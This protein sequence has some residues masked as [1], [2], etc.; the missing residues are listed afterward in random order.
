ME[1]HSVA[2]CRE[3]SDGFVA[4]GG[5]CSPD[6]DTEL[7]VPIS[8]GA[9]DRHAT[10]GVL[11]VGFRAR[12]YKN[13]LRGEYQ[14]F[15]QGLAHQAKLIL[16]FTWRLDEMLALQTIS[17][18][19]TLSLDLNDVLDNILHG[20]VDIL[21]F[22]F[23]TI[24]LVDDDRRLIRCVR[25]L[26]VPDKW[27]E[28]AVHPLDSRDIQAHVVRT[29]Q[30][31]VLAG[32]DDRFDRAI[33]EEFQHRD[34]IRVWVPIVIAD[35]ATRQERVIGTI[36]AGYRRM[37]RADI[38]GDQLRML[39]ALK[40]QA[41]IAIAHAQLLQRMQAKAD[42]LTGLHT[43]GQAIAFTRQP[44]QVLQQVAASARSLLG[45][46]IVMVYRYHREANKMDYPVIA[47]GPRHDFRLNLRLDE[48]TFL[49][50]VMQL[51]RPYYSADAPHD[52]QW[53]ARDRIEDRSAPQTTR[54]TFI[55]RHNIK[56]LAGIP[57]IADNETVGVMFV[58]YRKRHRFDEDERQVHELFAQQAAMAIANAESQKRQRDAIVRQERYHLSREL[59]HSVSQALYGIKVK[60]RTAQR[61]VAT[62]P[63]YVQAELANIQ[64]IAHFAS[65]ETGFIIDELRAPL[66]DSRRLFQGLHNYIQRLNHWYQQEIGLEINIDSPLPA[67]LEQK[68]VR[69][70]REAISNAVRH[71]RS[72]TV[73]VRCERHGQR[74]TVEVADDGVGFDPKRVPPRKVGL[75]SM[76]ELATSAGGVLDLRTGPGTGTCVCLTVLVDKV[77]EEP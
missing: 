34:M 60:A 77:K 61:H 58:N 74:V 44:D 20:V 6:V 9:G 39:E 35:P 56:S 17:Q 36:E 16:A 30:I 7:A 47:G 2:H 11:R 54:P 53:I 4:A 12:A 19:V 33:W 67:A 76:H 42:L 38:S 65:Q 21:G 71:A 73:R 1:H 28:M 45:A 40:N 24:S 26:N 51:T 41:S 15:V 69:F 59:H 57:L 8:L 22:E 75:K 13:R 70:A 10:A 48:D 63:G 49:T 66:E 14:N 3:A 64:E 29:G 62:D 72:R 25:G 18:Q 52:P 31:E 32:W 46:D 27:V 50:H 43:V 5:S 68:L 23:A 37:T 55:Q